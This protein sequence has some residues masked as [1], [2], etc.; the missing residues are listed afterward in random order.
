M[1]R[2]TVFDTEDDSEELLKAGKSGFDKQVTCIAALTDSGQEFF[3]DKANCVSEFLDWVQETETGPIYAH[4]LSYDLGNIFGKD[5]L[6]QFTCRM[7]PGSS[8]LIRA[9][10]RGRNW[11]DSFNL[12]PMSARKI[13]EKMGINKLQMDVRSREY[14]MTDCRIIDAALKTA[15]RI[16]NEFSISRLPSTVG[17]LAMK[18]WQNMGGENWFDDSTFSKEAYY[19][20]RTEVFHIFK[21]S[22]CHIDINSLYP[23][24]MLE[25]F[26]T[27]LRD[28]KD[29]EG[30]G[31]AEVEI[32]IPEQ[33]VTPLPFRHPKLKK[34]IF[35]FGRIRG[36]WTFHEIRN[37]IENFDCEIVKIYRASG[38][39]DGERYYAQFVTEFY[40]RRKKTEDEAMKL[41]FKLLLNNLY[42]QLGMKGG[43]SMSK[44]LM[45]WDF[46]SQGNYIAEGV[47]FGS[48]HLV[49][50]EFPL[51]EFC[52]YSHAS[53]ITSL[54]RIRIAN[55]LKKCPE[56]KLIYCDTDSIIFE[57]FQNSFEISEEL[58]KF[59]VEDYGGEVYI[60]AK[61][62]YIET[63]GQK[64][65]ICAKG[66]PKNKAKDFLFNKKATFPKPYRL[67]QAINGYNEGNKNQL[68]VW[69]NITKEFRGEKI[70]SKRELKNGKMMPLKVYV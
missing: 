23:S 11:L 5:A 1:N 20:G 43:I 63:G 39:K 49:D 10:A 17:G 36:V 51:R 8:R 40:E 50:C 27:E 35:P 18:I 28:K 48:K 2:F 41:F 60:F 61:K 58:G 38:S 25:P 37:A 44:D 21:P 45:P 7:I 26:P 46:D 14:V 33:F 29:I 65:I 52:N 34:L 30:W 13:G 15:F 64:N 3:S 67:R 54:A 24:V 9:R 6:D 31:I 62:C 59:K 69:R 19:G 70:K 16:A 22:F 42:G 66:V 56:D 47:P 12:Y 53:Y 55:E 68:S 57:P 32:K 4:N